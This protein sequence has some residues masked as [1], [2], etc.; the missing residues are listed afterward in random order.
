[1]RAVVLDSYRHCD[2][3]E[4]MVFQEVFNGVWDAVSPVRCDLAFGARQAIPVGS[5]SAFR[6][7]GTLGW[8]CVVASDHPLASMTGPL[9]DDTMRN[10]PSLVREDSSRTLQKRIT[11]LLDNQKRVVGPDWE[12]SANCLSAGLCVGMVQNDLSRRWID[13]GKW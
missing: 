11:W 9:S 6:Y 12:V 4:C 1:L 7:M 13:S 2:N 10:W 5:R 8:R 3:V